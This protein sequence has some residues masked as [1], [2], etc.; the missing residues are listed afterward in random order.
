[1]NT[2]KNIL[3]FYSNRHTVRNIT[4][5]IML[6]DIEAKITEES[7]NDNLFPLIT[8]NKY[9]VILLGS[10]NPDLHIDEICKIIKETVQIHTNII[11]LSDES[12]INEY[13]EIL[14]NENADEIIDITPFDANDFIINK[15]EIIKKYLK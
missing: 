13:K 8:E 14:S 3:V 5:A 15:C 6:S 2:G 11:L 4:N 1:M 9:N 12:N 10:D 7:D